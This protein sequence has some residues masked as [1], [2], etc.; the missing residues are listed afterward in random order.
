MFIEAAERGGDSLLSSHIQRKMATWLLCVVC[1][2][3]VLAPAEAQ[4]SY[5]Q[6]AESYRQGVD[7]ALQQL[8]SSDN[9]KLHFL[10]LRSVEKRE[11]EVNV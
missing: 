7:L 10:F 8:R 6:L 5:S 2:A 4:D 3:A 9:V 11:H 1:A